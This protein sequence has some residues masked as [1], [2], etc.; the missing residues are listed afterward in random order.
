MRIL[1]MEKRYSVSEIS[2][3]TGLT[4]RTVQYYDN[5]GVLKAVR[6]EKGHRLYSEEQLYAFEQIVF[7][8]S[9]G[10]SLSEIKEKL[11]TSTK[12]EDIKSVLD[13]QEAELNKQKHSLQ[14]KIDGLKVAKKLIDHGYEAPWEMLAKLLSSLVDDDME[15]WQDYRFSEEDYA[16]FQRAFS[17]KEMVLDFYDRFRRLTLQAAAYHASKVPIESDLAKNLAMEWGK[18]V[19]E[20]TFN[21][22]KIL[23]AFQSVDQ[24]RSHW[25]M[26]ETQLINEAETYLEAV[27][28][29]HE[30]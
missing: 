6:N 25:S 22:G 12:N 4:R 7:Y 14:I 10:F 23:A 5:E 18:M 19:E 16:Q 26:G 30:N 13:H 21:D 3:M 17:S 9:I 15:H 20:V 29:Y 2:K 27:L 8:K 24:D 28:R 11:V 1:D